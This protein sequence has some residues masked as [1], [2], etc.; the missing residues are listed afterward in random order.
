MWS[1]EK[2]LCAHVKQLIK[3]IGFGIE[4]V[5][6]SLSFWLILSGCRFVAFSSM[7]LKGA[8]LTLWEPI[9]SLKRD[10]NHMPTCI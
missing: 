1:H 5:S 7:C 9:S 2:E 3:E 4:I 6:P 8:T 10:Y